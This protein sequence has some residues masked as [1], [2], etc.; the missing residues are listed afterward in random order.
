MADVPAEYLA[1]RIDYNPDT[2]V[3]RWKPKPIGSRIDKMWN[4][5]FAGR[6]ITKKLARG[7]IQFRI[8]GNNLQAH[9]AAW[10][11]FHGVWPVG[12]IDHINRVPDDNRICNLR[13]ATCSENVINSRLRE[14]NTSG[15]RGVSRRSSRKTWSADISVNRRTIHLGTFRCTTAAAIAYDAAAK[16]L[17][18]D[19]AVLNF[20]KEAN[21]G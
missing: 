1:T 15:M 9:R 7:H 5:R 20:A 6:E 11:I 10:A 14:S 21:L 17:H 3:L 16:R 2:G 13:I 19:F 4:K 8:D 18:G 12:F